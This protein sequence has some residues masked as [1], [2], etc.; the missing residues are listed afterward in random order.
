[1]AQAAVQQPRDQTLP[2]VLT[3]QQVA[4]FLQ[5][6]RRQVERLGVP[7]LNLGRKTKRYV[8]EDVLAWL[9]AQRRR[10]QAA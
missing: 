1:V 9:E 8:R 5:V 10:S 6:Q 3:R 2:A 4:D 7:C